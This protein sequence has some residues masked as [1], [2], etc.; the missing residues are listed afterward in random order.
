[1]KPSYKPLGN[2]EDDSHSD[3]LPNYHFRHYAIRLGKDGQPWP[4]ML[5]TLIF[6]LL[7]VSLGGL[8]SSTLTACMPAN[9]PAEYGTFE[10]GFTTEIGVWTV[11]KKCGLLHSRS[12]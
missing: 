11:R 6:A 2:S 9:S 4:W 8:Y 12:L 3:R 10:D 7:S 5:A 1:M